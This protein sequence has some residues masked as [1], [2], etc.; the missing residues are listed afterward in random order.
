ME[1]LQ[2]LHNRNSAVAHLNANALRIKFSMLL[3]CINLELSVSV[4]IDDF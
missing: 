4:Q 2:N 1:R 3:K